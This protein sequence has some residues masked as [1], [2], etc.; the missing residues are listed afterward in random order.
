MKWLIVTSVL[1]AACG[2][3]KKVE[4]QSDGCWMGTVGSSSVEGCGNKTYTLRGDP[5]CAEIQ[6]KG[7]MGNGEGGTYLRVRIKGRDWVAA[8]SVFGFATVC[9]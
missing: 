4:V 3:S 9:Q 1:L 2:C 6:F 5:K 8:D 7:P